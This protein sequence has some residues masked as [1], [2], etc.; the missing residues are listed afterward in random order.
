MQSH[1]KKKY[2][3]IGGY[4]PSPIN[5][6]IED[7]DAKLK[8]EI[9]ESLSENPLPLLPP[10]DIT[11]K[12]AE[13]IIKET[14][15]KDISPEIIAKETID[16]ETIDKEAI[17]KEAI[18][19]E[20]RS[21]E[22]SPEIIIKDLEKNLDISI[23]ARDIKQSQPEKP[24]LEEPKSEEKCTDAQKSEA[25]NL[26]DL[27]YMEPSSIK[28]YTIK[29]GTILFHGSTKATFDPKNIRL[30]EKRLTAYFSSNIKLAS[31][32]ISGCAKYPLE[33]GYIHKFIVNRDI[34]N[35]LILSSFEINKDWN[36][37]YFE[38]Y[39]CNS[40]IP[41]L[42]LINGV[43]FFYSNDKNGF[44]SEFALCDPSRF[45]DY[46]SSQQC[47]SRRKISMPYNFSK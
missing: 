34:D 28:K 37:D 45:L 2:F 42:G 25:A 18:G 29:A 33:S 12:T 10:P 39:F 15:S 41:E 8:R 26:S 1:K 46:V 47:I 43:G 40:K 35:I 30:G 20:S 44:D 6:T 32:Y 21:K 7:I 17:G 14:T 5:I 23:G 3:L 16:K 27:E 36:L 19:Q 4:D 38:S 31:D 11:D 13:I 24:K 9:K 22:L